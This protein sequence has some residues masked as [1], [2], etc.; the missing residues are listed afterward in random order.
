[1]LPSAA[2]FRLSQPL[3]SRGRALSQIQR[4]YVA[5]GSNMC[6][7][8][9]AARCPAARPIGVAALPARAFLI[10]R[11]GFATLVAAPA[12]QAYGL[13]WAVTA[14]DEHSLDRYEAVAEGEYRKEAVI[15][16]EHGE[17]LIYIAADAMP[18]KPLAAYLDIILA[19]AAVAGLPLAY[20]AELASW[21]AS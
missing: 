13:V 21:R 7:A 16:A 17:A 4:R 18:G 5:Y 6:R 10:N 1:L 11:L 20:Q 19:A 8:Q 12:A 2:S 15:L 3:S 14:E 9:M